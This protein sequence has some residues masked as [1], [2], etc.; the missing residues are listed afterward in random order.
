MPPGFRWATIAEFKANIKSTYEDPYYDYGGWSEYTYDSESRHCFL[1]QESKSVKDCLFV[2][3]GG[4]DISTQNTDSDSF[5][6]P[7][8]SWPDFAGLVC[9]RE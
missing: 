7:D 9:I 2:H 5:I 1:F 8:P 3:A 6:Y 4:G